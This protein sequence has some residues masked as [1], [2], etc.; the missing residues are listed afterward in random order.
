MV[1]IL[2]INSEFLLAL[3]CGCRLGVS[4]TTIIIVYLWYLL[5]Y[6]FACILQHKTYSI[7]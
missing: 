4:K 6:C 5:F 1:V 3:P 7:F 2:I